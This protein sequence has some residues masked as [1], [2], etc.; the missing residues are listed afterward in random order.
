MPEGASPQPTLGSPTSSRTAVSDC[1]LLV[2]DLKGFGRVGALRRVPAGDESQLDGARS[3]IGFHF[4]HYSNQ[5]LEFWTT[6]NKCTILAKNRVSGRTDNSWWAAVAYEKFNTLASCISGDKYGVA[7]SGNSVVLTCR[8]RILRL[9]AH[10]PSPRVFMPS[11]L[12]TPVAGP[13]SASELSKTLEFLV[14]AKA[15][16]KE[17]DPSD[18]D[19]TQTVS[20]FGD[21]LAVASVNKVD[22]LTRSPFGALDLHLAV[23]HA[24]R[25]ND[26]LSVVGSEIWVEQV[27]RNQNVSHWC[28]RNHGGTQRM[29]LPARPHS[30][31][32]LKVVK[33]HR[34][35]PVLGLSVERRDLCQALA[36]LSIVARKGAVLVRCGV[37]HSQRVEIELYSEA[38][39]G[40]GDLLSSAQVS[41]NGTIADVPVAIE[42][43][44]CF[45]VGLK[46]FFQELR[47]YKRKQ[48]ILKY[49]DVA[50]RLTLA[51]R[52]DSEG[53]P[54]AP[55][56]VADMDAIDHSESMLRA[57]HAPQ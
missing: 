29:W 39:G 38:K 36:T 18:S 45:E 16:R 43:P 53:Q 9:P 4:L 52:E 14:G 34:K 17:G 10:S 25:L 7:Y 8:G 54:V 22:R 30:D 3:D 47:R 44:V 15:N 5:E 50:R 33:S 56:S 24:R 40:A 57:S 46:S 19:K 13:I 28:F 11:E 2:E 20:F 49:S 42:A 12:G 27:S 31:V 55:F 48:V 23:I 51:T 6:D 32:I 41:L 26:W 1:E 35:P 37:P 21:G